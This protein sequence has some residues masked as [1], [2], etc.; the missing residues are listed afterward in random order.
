MNTTNTISNINANIAIRIHHDIRI[1]GYELRS[2]RHFSPS[3]I[4]NFFGIRFLIIDNI[5]EI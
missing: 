3:N 4:I 1:K 2:L 5:R